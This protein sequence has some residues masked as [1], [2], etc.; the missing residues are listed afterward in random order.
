MQSVSHA[1]EVTFLTGA[2]AGIG[3]SLALRL[4]ADGAPI[5]VAAR[6]LPALEALVAEIRTRGGESLAVRCDVT[7]PRSVRE[8]IAGA[9]ARFGPVTRLVANAGGSETT[10]VDAFEADHVAR[11]LDLNVLG[12]ARCIEAVLPGMLKRGAGH[13]VA[14]SSLAAYRGLPGA[15]AYSA[16]K[17]ALTRLLEGL[18][19]DLRGR[20]ID[21]T[22]IAP[23]FVRQ[24]PTRGDRPFMLEL[25]PATERMARAIRARR[26]Y[27]AFPW[28]L[29]ALTRAASLL[30]PAVYDRLVAGR[31]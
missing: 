10:R 27:Y 11:Q 19:V 16:A 1:A 21:V 8:A 20:G 22:V 13:L 12:V 25:E 3:R 6:S 18:R 29:A 24:H 28:R 23:G 5:A 26:A 14:T 4:A 7:D 31:S 17:A 2:S 15:A 9:E 30:P